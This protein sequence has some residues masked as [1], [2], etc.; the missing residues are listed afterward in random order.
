MLDELQRLPHPFDE[1]ADPTHVTASAVV[2]GPLGVVLH[3]HRRLRRWMQP[4]GHVD[5]GEAPGGAA[6][7]ESVEETGL[8][9]AHP[10]TGP[11]LLHVDVHPAA[12]GHVHLDLRYLLW[13]AD[14]EPAPGPGESQEVAWFTWDEAEHLADEALVGALVAARRLT[15]GE[16]TGGA[17]ARMEDR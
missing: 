6:L 5:P 11:E 2:V 16:A 9:L 8:A 7:R 15:G 13:S 4:G 12:A 10:G 14:A 1:D 17:R 3:R